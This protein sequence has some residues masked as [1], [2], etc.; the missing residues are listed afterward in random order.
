MIHHKDTKN[1]AIEECIFSK[2][3]FHFVLDT[4]FPS[5]YN[6]CSAKGTKDTKFFVKYRGEE[7][8]EDK[9]LNNMLFRKSMFQTLFP[10]CKIEYV[11]ELNFNKF[12]HSYAIRPVGRLD[13]FFPRYLQEFISKIMNNLNVKCTKQDKIIFVG[14]KENKMTGNNNGS[15]ILENQNEIFDYCQSK[16]SSELVYFENM[17]WEEQIKK[18]SESRIMIGMHGSGLTNSIFMRRDS[19]LIEIL[20]E[21]F[22]FDRFK[23]INEICGNKY[24]PIRSEPANRQGHFVHSNQILN[25]KLFRNFIDEILKKERL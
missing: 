16:I 1:I 6:F 12:K 8:N 2:N 23:N 25:V 19:L 5:Y 14:R 13:L 24:L 3:Y 17:P 18:S 10:E 22:Y 7:H 20:P 21:R 11:K 9:C 4:L 15:R